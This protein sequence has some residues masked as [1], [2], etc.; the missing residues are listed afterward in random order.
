MGDLKRVGRV[1]LKALIYFEAVSTV[2]LAIGLLVGEVAAA[3]QRLQHR[4][5]RRSIPNAVATYVTKAKEEG[6]VAHLLGII[7]G[8]LFRRARP[9]RPAAGAAGLDPLRLCHR[10]PRRGRASRCSHAVDQ[11]AQDVLRHHPHDRAARADR[12]IRRDGVHRRRLRPRLAVEPDRADR[13]L[14]S[15]Q[16]S[17]RAGRA[18]HDRAAFGLLDPSL[19]RLHQ[20]RAADRARHLVVGNRAAA[21]DAEDGASRRVAVGGR[22]R[23]SDRLQLQSRR[24]QYLHDA[25][26]AVPG[27]GDQY[28]SDD[29]AGT[30]HSRGR[31]ASP[32]RAPPAS[33]APASSRWRRR[34][35]SCRTSRS[36]RSPSS[37]AST[38]S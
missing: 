3:R 1:G 10:A 24:H 12:R 9:R 14:L 37:S 28:P 29:L 26:D 17:V 15:H 35:R 8:Q 6:I 5:R 4:S 16:H 25:G 36:S 30:R 19:H 20:G 11:A 22:P 33:P 34:C 23:H 2:A 31:H 21:D 18:R 13:D 7:P 32:R 38:S 27:A